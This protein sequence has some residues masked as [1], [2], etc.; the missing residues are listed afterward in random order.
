M[1]L[2]DNQRTFL[3]D[4]HFAVV[5]TISADGMPHQTVMWYSLE[6]DHVLLNTPYESVKHK[7]LKRDPRIS[8]CVEESYQYVTFQGTVVLTEDP[9]EASADYARLGQRY[10]G[11]FNQRP[12][13]PRGGSGRPPTADRVT[14]RVEV[15]RILSNGLG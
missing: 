10:A 5:A 11:T 1:D 15:Q 9:E 7:H 14:I 13:R 8:I 2:N 6:D 3:E 12:A 4:V